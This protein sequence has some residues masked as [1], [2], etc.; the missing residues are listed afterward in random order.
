MSL[1][2]WTRCYRSVYFI[3]LF[4]LVVAMELPICHLKSVSLTS[5]NYENSSKLLHKFISFYIVHLESLISG[6]LLRFIQSAN[7]LG[8]P[9]ITVPVR[10][11]SLYLNSLFILNNDSMSNTWNGY[12]TR[13][14]HFH[15]TLKTAPLIDLR[16]TLKCMPQLSHIVGNVFHF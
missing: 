3:N 9:A 13:I 6:Y 4:Q 7:L 1:W 8:F 5:H 10:D 16:D 2:L 11:T 12:V 15:L 14:W